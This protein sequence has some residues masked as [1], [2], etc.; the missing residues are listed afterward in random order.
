[1][2]LDILRNKIDQ[3]DEK[4]ID[5]I[6][7]RLTVVNKIRKIK[8]KDGVPVTDKNREIDVLAKIRSHSASININEQLS[9]KIF[10][11][12]IKESKRVQEL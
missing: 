9:E 12:I 7:Q 5:L 6:G 1:M 2:K 4:I 8:K 11:L 10:R 3:I